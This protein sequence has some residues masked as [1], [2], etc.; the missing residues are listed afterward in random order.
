LPDVP[1]DSSSAHLLLGQSR[2]DNWPRLC[3]DVNADVRQK[4]GTS[5]YGVVR[6]YTADPATLE[7]LAGRIEKVLSVIQAIQGFVSYDVVVSGNTLIAISVYADKA[8]ADESTTTARHY[9]QEEWSDLSIDP[10]RVTEG[11]VPVHAAS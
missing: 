1:V 6:Q 5:M 4:A 2:A 9:V 8:G 7:D 3:H 11:E 10:P